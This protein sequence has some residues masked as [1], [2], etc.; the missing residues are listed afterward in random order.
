MKCKELGV[1][2]LFHPDN[3]FVPVEC[4]E[5]DILGLG[6][7]THG[8]LLYNKWRSRQIKYLVEYHGFRSIGFESDILNIHHYFT[9]KVPITDITEGFSHPTMKELFDWLR[10][11]NDNHPRDKVNVFGI[12][13]QWYREVKGRDRITRLYRKY[14]KK[15]DD[16]PAYRD[17]YMFE[18]MEEQY[19]GNKTILLMH[20]GHLSKVALEEDPG[21]VAAED[22][23]EWDLEES[24]PF[25]SYIVE[26]MSEKKYVVIA[27]TMIRGS[28]YSIKWPVLPGKF[29][30]LHAKVAVKD[31]IYDSKCPVF[32]TK[33][34]VDY[35]YE[36]LM[37]FDPDEPEKYFNKASSHGY[38]M[39]IL[40]ND[41][42]PLNVYRNNWSIWNRDREVSFYNFNPNQLPMYRGVLA[43]KKER[44]TKKRS[45]KK[46]NTTKKG[47]R[48]KN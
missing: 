44:K 14:A 45:K 16:N 25:G 23:E 7:G 47:K 48:I 17:Q 43:P 3:P 20:N 21:K 8:S 5:A 37:A 19:G 38:D 1:N 12:D 26:R 39:V 29:D 10:K 30:V 6:E 28:Y 27:N 18:A 41:E 40:I 36:G 4:L 15:L 22:D 2:D 13:A 46:K 35:I 42:E 9:G 33:P 11:W 32:F 34:P 31:P 24:P